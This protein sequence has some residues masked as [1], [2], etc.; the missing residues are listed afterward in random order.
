MLRALER[1]GRRHAAADAGA[2]SGRRADRA[3]RYELPAAPASRRA[4]EETFSDYRDVDGLQVAFSAAVQ[5]DGVPYVTRRVRSFDT[6]S[7]SIRAL[8]Q[9]ELTLCSRPAERR[10]PADPRPALRVMISCG[11]P[12][13][14][15]Y[16]GALARE[17]LQLE[18]VA[19]ITGFGGDRLRAAG[20]RLVGDFKRAL[21]DRP[22]RSRARAAAH[23]RDVPPARRRRRGRP[24]RRLRR[25]RFSR[26]QLPARARDAEAAACRSSTTSARSSGRGGRAGMKTMKRHRRSRAGDLPVRGAI[27]RD[28]GRAGGVGRPSAARRHAAPRRSAR[29]VPRAHRA[30]SG[31]GRSSRCCPGSRRNEVRA[32]L[33]DLVDAAAADSRARSRRRSSSSRARRTST[34]SCSRRSQR[35]D[36]AARPVVV[37]GRA[38]DVLA[39]RRCR[40][41]RVGHGHGAGGAARLPDGR[42]LSPV[43]A[44]LPAR[45][46]VRARRHVRDG[47]S[48]R[49]ARASSPS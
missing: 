32:I 21:G 18:P 25:D 4:I 27:Y 22:A 46:A 8:H 35:L 41:R 19:V 13:G 24:A 2:R 37:D 36:A 40:A 6:T 26:L 1:L 43:A 14:D 31:R 28:G 44:D 49:R 33:P 17:I 20:A 48:R 3:Q 42:R 38:D 12:S 5:R 29:A 16:A 15:L 39:P 11:E 10:T 23:L 45:Q 47:E 7:R 30:R 9:A 34:T